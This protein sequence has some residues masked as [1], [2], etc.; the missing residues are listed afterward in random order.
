MLLIKKSALIRESLVQA[1][2][3]SGH[4]NFL[5]SHLTGDK[6]SKKKLEDSESPLGMGK[7]ARGTSQIGFCQ[8]VLRDDLVPRINQNP[9]KILMD[10]EGRAT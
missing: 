8:K 6:G 7:G 9:G 2:R 5:P 3:L 4:P 10:L 1:L